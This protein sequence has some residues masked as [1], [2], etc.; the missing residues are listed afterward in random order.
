MPAYVSS[1]A[2]T[3]V[4]RLGLL[5]RQVFFPHFRLERM[6]ED[7]QVWLKRPLAEPLLEGAVKNVVYLREL[8]HVQMERLFSTFVRCVDVYLGAV[9]D[10]DDEDASAA[11]YETHR[12]P[13]AVQAVLETPPTWPSRAS[14]DYEQPGLVSNV[15]VGVDDGMQFTRNVWRSGRP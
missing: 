8:R 4:T 3:L 15:L 10:A 13:L 11:P 6:R 9:R 2:H 1:V 12:V 7:Q 14:P 5:P